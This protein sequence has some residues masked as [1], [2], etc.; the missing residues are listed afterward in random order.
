[1]SRRRSN[2]GGGGVSLFPFLSILACLIGILTLMIK[3]VSDMRD[4]GPQERD[5]EELARSEEFLAIETKLKQRRAEL[6]KIEADLKQ[7]DGAFVELQDLEDRQVVLR[8]KLEGAKAKPGE[9]DAELQKRTENLLDQ[10]SALAKE[11]PALE[12]KAAELKAELEKRK[13]KPDSTPAPVV[14]Q[15][16]GS[17]VTRNTPMFFIECHGSGVNIL[18]KDGSKTAVS[19]AAITTEP[20]LAKVMNEAKS[21]RGSLVLFLI[22]GNGHGTYQ[23]AAGWAEDQF[24]VRTGKLPIPGSGAIDLTLFQPR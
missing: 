10:I 11:R 24:K 13:I 19:T 22:R 21:A 20:A 3:L 16:G 8:K 15:P 17:G 14:V 2:A 4:A 1:M 9:S 23:T 18:G 6:V 7:R 12:K 5:P